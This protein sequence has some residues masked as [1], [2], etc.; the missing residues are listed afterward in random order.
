MH[1]LKDERGEAVG[2]EDIASDGVKDVRFE[3]VELRKT[4]VE[5]V[6]AVGMEE[7]LGHAERRVL[8]VVGGD[9]HLSLYLSACSVE[10]A[11]AQWLVGEAVQLTAYE[12]QATLHVGVVATEIDAPHTRV[13][14]SADI[15]LDGID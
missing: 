2:V 4:I 9:G 12:S 8:A 3:G 14:V 10:G 13:G 15:T 6:G 5:G 11:L 1:S 7:E